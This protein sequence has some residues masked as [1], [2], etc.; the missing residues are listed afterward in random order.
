VAISLDGSDDYITVADA[1]DLSPPGD[2]TVMA[3]V[4]VV[5]RD[6]SGVNT[7]FVGKY[8]GSGNEREWALSLDVQF[9]INGKLVA[10][11]SSDGTYQ[12]DLMLVDTDFIPEGSWQHVAL[13]FVASTSITLYR[14][15]SEVDQ[16]T[17]SIP[18][19][20]YNGSA[21][22]A[23]GTTYG[24]GAPGRQMNGAVTD[25]VLIHE[26]LTE[27]ELSE[28]YNAKRRL[29]LRYFTSNLKLYLPLMGPSEMTATTSHWG[30]QDL[31]GNGHDVN[32]VVSAPVWVADPIAPQSWADGLFGGAGPV[33]AVAARYPATRRPL[34]YRAGPRM[35]GG[36]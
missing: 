33:E 34:I 31:S 30:A 32:S 22:V 26:A 14:N 5:D 3:W 28:I 27:A 19:S 35:I 16:K 9:G 25:V 23:V 7:A 17:S 20:I 24:Y 8:V 4:Y 29:P 36:T 6:S 18:A 1:D 15:G 2:F 10:A 13:V 21:D 12:S 11:F